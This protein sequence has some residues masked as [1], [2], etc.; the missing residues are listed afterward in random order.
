MANPVLTPT[1][2]DTLQNIVTMRLGY[3]VGATGALTALSRFKGNPGIVS[4]ARNSAG[5]Y[6][7]TLRGTYPGGCVGF[8]AVLFGAYTTAGGTVAQVTVENSD[9]AT[10]IITVVFYAVGTQTATEVDSGVEVVF[11][12]V[13]K[14]GTV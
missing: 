7:F 8:S 5:S 3:S 1:D 2:G 13:L 11:T 4:V 6:T 10:P 9:T 14:N 12:F